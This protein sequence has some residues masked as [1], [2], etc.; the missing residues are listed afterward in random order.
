MPMFTKQ[1]GAGY[2][3]NGGEKE[4]THYLAMRL[5]RETELRNKLCILG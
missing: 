2:R 5:M 3:E 4:T 1:F